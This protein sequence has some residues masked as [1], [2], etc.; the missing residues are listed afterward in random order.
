MKERSELHPE[1]QEIIPKFIKECANAGYIIKIGECVRSVSEQD[2][3]Y[4]IGR[5][6]GTKGKTV[7]NCK[8]SNYGS[9]HIWGVAFDF[10]LDMDVDKDGSK[11]DDAFNDKT[12]IFTKVGQIG[13]KYGL[14]W[15][16]DFRSIHDS[17]HFQMTKYS[18][19]YTASYLKKKYGTP[20]KFKATW[21][22]K[23][24]ET[25][26]EPIKVVDPKTTNNTNIKHAYQF[27][28]V[29]SGDNLSKIA[30]DYNTT[31]D[32]LVKL[33]SIK[34]ANNIDIGKKLLITTYEIYQVVKGD[35][36]SKISKMFLGNANRYKDIMTLN[37]MKGSALKIGQ[38]LK[39]PN[40]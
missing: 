19:D 4:A 8:G 11:K 6:T 24:V 37:G 30:K 35:S 34:D 12:G 10:F 23:I 33:N 36:L 28:V 20:D 27:Y 31:V 5:T 16:G 1:L 29:K 39:I 18:P 3:L 22:K 9:L 14:T 21:R 26:K 32:M 15:G 17:P 7:T 25:V 38:E 40:K 13:K 2:E